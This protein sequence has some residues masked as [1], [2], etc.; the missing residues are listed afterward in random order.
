MLPVFKPGEIALVHPL[1]PHPSSLIL[2]P[3]DCAVYDLEGRILLHR[4]VKTGPE[5][6]WLADDAGR[7]E[8]HLVPWENIRGKV[9]SRNP[10]AGGLCGY[11]YSKIRRSLALLFV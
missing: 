9:L 7:L 5:G 1:I 10:L 6:A 11:I 2:S 8:P 4:V 3:G